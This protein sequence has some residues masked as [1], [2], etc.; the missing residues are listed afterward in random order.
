MAQRCTSGAVKWRADK[1][2][3]QLRNMGKLIRLDGALGSSLGSCASHS[4]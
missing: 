2:R 1:V 4:C 3:L